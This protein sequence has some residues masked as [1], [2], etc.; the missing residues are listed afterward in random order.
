VR[1]GLIAPP[2]VPVPP[3]AYGGTEVVIDNLARALHAL[4]HQVTLFTVGESTCPVTREYLYSTAVEPLGASVE[5]AAH[6]LAAHEALSG[7]D[8]IHDHTTLGPLLSA[9][10]G[11][12]RPP[13]VTTHHGPF[14]ACNRRI[15]AEIARHA[16]VVAISHDQARRALGVPI[17]AVIHHGIDLDV[18]QPGT[19]EAEH[20]VFLGRMS[21]DKGVDRAVRVARESGRRLVLATKMREPAERAYYTRVVRPI[22]GPDDDLSIEP[23]IAVRVAMLRGASALINPICWPEPF[24][25]VMI[26]SLAAATPVL[27][28]PNGA[29]PEIVDDGHTGFLCADELEMIKAVGRLAE[30][31]RAACRAAAEQRFSMQRM[32]LDYERLYRQ[33]LDDPPAPTRGRSQAGPSRLHPRVPY[34]GEL[35][36]SAVP[37]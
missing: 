14:N 29:A 12:G 31:D 30:L 7:V 6:V 36:E 20:L 28:F 16:S 25:L 32:A 21:P 34:A 2:W 8:I 27:T 18:Y 37:Q 24:G 3:P 4:G 33:I 19:G 10:R 11:I 26:E 13:V 9:G 17:A 22:L 23:P 15:F 35:L 5:E 1:I